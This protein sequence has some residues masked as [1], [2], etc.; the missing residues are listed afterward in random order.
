MLNTRGL[1]FVDEGAD[2]RNYTYA[3]Y[4]RAILAQP[5]GVAFQ[6]FDQRVVEWL[7]KEEYADEVVRKIYADSIEELSQKLILDGLEDPTQFTKTI[8]A[9]NNAVYSRQNA[10]PLLRWDPSVKDGLSTHSPVLASG[11]ESKHEAA[12]HS[13]EPSS[14]LSNSPG[15]SHNEKLLGNTREKYISPAKSNWALPLDKP[16]FLAVKVACGI[17]FT[18]GGIAVDAASASVLRTRDETVGG[19][20]RP[21]V[22][23]H[24]RMHDR[25]DHAFRSEALPE[26]LPQDSAALEQVFPD[27][28]KSDS[29]GGPSVALEY[30]MSAF[31]ARRRLPSRTLPPIPGLFCAGEMVGGIFHGNYPG[32]SGLTSGAVFGRLAGQS[33]ADVARKP[34]GPW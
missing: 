19:V 33:A 24:D 26:P 32:G 17:T 16:P 18:F 3:K 20:A 4:G 22:C 8:R 6:V 27:H 23:M 2:F 11:L 10:Y 7:R 15:L 30:K 13:T 25:N 12:Q 21:D 9:Y 14:I 34:S 5:G 31:S 28:V 29:S 1:R